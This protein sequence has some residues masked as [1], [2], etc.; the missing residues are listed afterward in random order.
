MAGNT[1]ST[2]VLDSSF[3]LAYLFP[4]EKV[5]HVQLFFNRYKQQKIELIASPILPFEVLNGLKTGILQKRV[6]YKIA[7]QLGKK[8]LKLPI[9]S[10][11]IN[12]IKIFKLS[13][14]HN[15][16]FY[17]ASYLS[18]AQTNNFPL[19]TLDKKLQKLS[20]N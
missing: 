4:D 14:L 5:G 18:L 16:S 3:I 9:K 1:N 12:F 6:D 20:Q 10:G 13:S 7:L 2:Y 8:F 15:L 17:D 19:L 11:E